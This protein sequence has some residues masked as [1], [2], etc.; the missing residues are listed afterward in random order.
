M[1]K[2]YIICSDKERKKYYNW[3]DV[4]GEINKAQR[5]TLQQAK[6]AKSQVRG[7]SWFFMEF[8]DNGRLVEVP[9]EVF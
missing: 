9:W 4:Q 2:K 5:F 6:S 1:T 7:N 3:P 8:D